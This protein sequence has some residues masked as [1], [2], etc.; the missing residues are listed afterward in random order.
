ME[1]EETLIDEP[2]AEEEILEGEISAEEFME[3]PVETIAEEV[4]AEQL[5]DVSSDDEN[6]IEEN[7]AVV[8][9]ALSGQCGDNVNWTLDNGVL[10]ISGTGDMYDYGMME[11]DSYAPWYNRRSEITSIIIESG[12]TIIGEDAF[13]ECS[14]LTSVT[15]PSGITSIGPL[16]PYY[17]ILC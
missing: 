7:E 1:E 14:A 13:Y 6:M 16:F 3:E 12:I 2:I 4:P 8:V 11:H 9:G 17:T 10:T 5:G 15:I